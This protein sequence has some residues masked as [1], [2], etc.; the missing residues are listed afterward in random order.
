MSHRNNYLKYY[1]KKSPLVQSDI[2]FLFGTSDKSIVSRLEK[3]QRNPNV[4]FLLLYHCIFDASVASFYEPIM[5]SLVL[6]LEKRIRLLI[7]EISK[8][9]NPSTMKR[10]CFLNEVITRLINVKS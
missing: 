5:D 3:G 1:R 10:I 9:N 2:A 6:G 7:I 4:E 8:S